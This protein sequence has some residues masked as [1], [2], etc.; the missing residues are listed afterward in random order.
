MSIMESLAVAVHYPNLDLFYSDMYRIVGPSAIFILPVL[1][2]LRYK[3]I[4]NFITLKCLGMMTIVALMIVGSLCVGWSWVY[5]FFIFMVYIGIIT[6]EA[7]IQKEEQNRQNNSQV[8]DGEHKKKKR[9][10]S[11]T[12]KVSFIIFIIASVIKVILSYLSY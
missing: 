2:Y 1:L 5:L 8:L 6:F 3:K 12:A 10:L 9:K 11:R 4:I 7:E